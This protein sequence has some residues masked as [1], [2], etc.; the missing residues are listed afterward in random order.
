MNGLE[1][2]IWLSLASHLYTIVKTLNI[3]FEPFFNILTRKNYITLIR[4]RCSNNSLTLEKCRWFKIPREKRICTLYFSTDMGDTLVI[5]DKLKNER[6][7]YLKKYYF[8]QTNVLKFKQLF[9]YK[10]AGTLRKLYQFINI[11][12]KF[13]SDNLLYV[14][15][16]SLFI[17]LLLSLRPTECLVILTATIFVNV[18]PS[19][20]TEW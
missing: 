14:V 7:T 20:V 4:F 6:L 16:I 5:C 18:Y 3:E 8:I 11:I 2:T 9:N 10:N 1:K 19:Y 17:Y 13:Y 15:N 12:N